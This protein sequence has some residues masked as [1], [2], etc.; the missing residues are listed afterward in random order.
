MFSIKSDFV[1]QAHS[2]KNTEATVHGLAVYSNGPLM[3]R[4]DAAPSGSIR[5]AAL[6]KQSDGTWFTKGPV[7][8]HTRKEKFYYR[9]AKMAGEDWPYDPEKYYYLLKGS[10]EASFEVL[11]TDIYRFL[12]DSWDDAFQILFTPVSIYRDTMSGTVRDDNLQTVF[13]DRMALLDYFWDDYFFEDY[14]KCVI[15]EL[16][17]TFTA[18]DLVSF[19]QFVKR[20]GDVLYAPGDIDFC[21]SVFPEC[22]DLVMM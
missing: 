6:V 9:L 2:A 3:I 21:Q 17:K 11:E 14:G 16:M 20:N 10:D 12:K 13:V 15:D 7:A 22:R 1:A 8:L 18:D 5:A 4:A 19:P